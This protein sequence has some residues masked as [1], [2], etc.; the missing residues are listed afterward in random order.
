MDEITPSPNRRVALAH[1]P[2]Y[3]VLDLATG[4]NLTLEE[5]I[6]VG[7][8]G[9]LIEH[10]RLALEHDLIEGRV[11]YVC[12]SCHKPMVL[13]SIPADK[14]TENRFFLKHRFRSDECGG[15]VGKTHEAICALRYANTKESAEHRRYKQLLVQSLACD[16][17]FSDSQPEVRWFDQDGV[18]WRQ[19]D[20][21]AMYRGQRIALEVQLSTTFVE[22]VAQ[23][24]AFYRRN[25]GRLVWFFRDLDVPGFRQ[26]E[27]DIFHTNNRN[28]F[29]VD[30]S[31]L[32][33]SL[34]QGRCMLDCAWEEPT[35]K[36]GSIV[37]VL[38]RKRV[39]FDELKF[40]VS[41]IG[42]PRA[43]YFDYEAARAMLGPPV[44]DAEKH[45]PAVLT[46]LDGD[47]ALRGLMDELV[48]GWPNHVD[49]QALW[50]VVRAK[51]ERR[52]FTLPEHFR[53]DPI[54]PFLQTAYSAK[55]G[56]VVLGGHSF[57]IQLANNLFNSHKRALFVFSVMMEHYSRGPELLSK[58]DRQGWLAKVRTYRQA[59][60]SGDPAYTP[61]RTYEDLLCF[62]FPQAQTALR[63]D[64][65]TRALTPA[66]RSTS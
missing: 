3:G 41:D 4:T 42:A 2:H 9:E 34:A 39:A 35:M 40:D 27:D 16:H 12:Q 45:L 8:Y 6:G 14:Y 54:F 36:D 46:I 59:W 61:D 50:T 44:R 11:R 17:T 53:F 32:A 26:A 24:Q 22:V 25:F 64:A 65:K 43:Y 58:G 55:Y 15:T 23:R 31:T 52:G 5:F 49:N 19:P 63:S 38:R 37:N 28:A 21:Q 56:R 13:R 18:R 62:L 30:E 48:W 1:N 10:R 7:D 33:D 60:Y 20:V 66:D 57:L 29:L 47:D 51:F